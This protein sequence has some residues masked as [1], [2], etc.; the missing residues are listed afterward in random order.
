MNGDLNLTSE[1]PA[2]EAVGDPTL[3][4]TVEMAETAPSAPKFAYDPDPGFWKVEWKRIKKHR[5]LIAFLLPA[6]M[7]TLIFGYVPMCGVIFAFRGSDFN[8]QKA[9]LLYNLTHASWTFQNFI[10]IFYDDSF[11]RAVGNTLL[12]SVIRLLICFPLSIL[13]AVQ[14]SDLK[15]Q[16]LAKAILI[17]LSIPN[18]LSWAIVIGIWQ[19]FLDPT[20]GLLGRYTGNIMAENA[21]FKPLV[22]FFS[23]WKSGGWGCILYYSAIMAIDKTYY[24]SAT[25]EG[26]NKLQK[27]WYLTIPS[28]LPT[29]ALTL[30]L[31]ISGM[32]AT[33]FELVYTM[34]QVD[35]GTLTEAQIVLDTYIYN[36][37][38]VNTPTNVPFATALGVFNGLIG[39]ILMVGGNYITSKTLKRGLW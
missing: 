14:L 9:D 32:M 23:A 29:I 8:L 33:G 26:A 4:G 18:F 27:M 12:I 31:N 34:M 28:I 21:W 2:A 15:N 7:I 38:V 13:I 1:S 22:I 11:G 16:G 3:P 10:D 25:L 35:P 37:S 6:V 5:N 17:I 36:I 30:V 39:L 24:E 20:I 19:G